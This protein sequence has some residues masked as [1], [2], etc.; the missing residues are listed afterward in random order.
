MSATS[1]CLLL[2]V[3]GIVGGK[4]VLFGVVFSAVSLALIPLLLRSMMRACY[5]LPLF[6][7][8]IREAAKRR[9]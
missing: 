1:I 8:W 3:G 6:D 9:K 7:D 2:G 5:H 4:Y